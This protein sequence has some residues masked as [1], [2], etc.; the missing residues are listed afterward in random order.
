MPLDSVQR[1]GRYGLD[2]TGKIVLVPCDQDYARNWA[3]SKRPGSNSFA[4]F[5]ALAPAPMAH[6]AYNG[7]NFA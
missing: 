6:S 4:S 2:A 5:Q 1:N 7:A 3:L